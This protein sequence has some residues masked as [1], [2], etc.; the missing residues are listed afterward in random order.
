MDILP[1]I[2]GLNE[3]LDLG[4]FRHNFITVFQL[5]NMPTH[6]RF[7]VG[8]VNGF[9]NHPPSL[10]VPPQTDSHG[11]PFY[12]YIIDVPLFIKYIKA[13]QFLACGR[14]RVLLKYFLKYTIPVRRVS[15]YKINKGKLKIVSDLGFGVRV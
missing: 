11:S 13:G 5:F 14:V 2:K 1:S 15:F 7:F 4:I 9:C 3:I 6:I 12:N 10:L 8:F